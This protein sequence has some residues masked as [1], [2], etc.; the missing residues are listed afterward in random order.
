MLGGV[1]IAALVFAG[2]ATLLSDQPFVVNL[3][4]GVLFGLLYVGIQ[5]LLARRAQRS[6]RDQV[7][8][9]GR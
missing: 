9:R 5:A 8:G 6:L 2:V 7:L 4:G 1:L 3:G